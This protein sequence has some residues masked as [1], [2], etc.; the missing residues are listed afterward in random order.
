MFFLAALICALFG[1]QSCDESVQNAQ[2]VSEFV[3][4]TNQIMGNPVDS[5]MNQSGLYGLISAYQSAIVFDQP[6][7]QAQYSQQIDDVMASLKNE[8]VKLYYQVNNELNSCYEVIDF[9]ETKGVHRTLCDLAV[10]YWSGDDRWQDDYDQLQKIV[11]EMYVDD[12]VDAEVY[13]GMLGVTNGFLGS[14]FEEVD[15][16][17]EAVAD[18]GIS[19]FETAPDNV[20][21]EFVAANQ[22]VKA[23]KGERAKEIAADVLDWLKLGTQFFVAVA[24]GITAAQGVSNAW[25]G[26]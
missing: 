22:E 9:M 14:V 23:N 24:E 25:N 5:Y 16:N 20:S 18:E 15:S 7:L 1:F 26:N 4:L 19:N 17:A 3:G 8:D 13:N 12:N 2:D 11:D 21:Y 10:A 6:D